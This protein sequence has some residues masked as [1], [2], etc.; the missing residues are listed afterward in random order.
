TAPTAAYKPVYPANTSFGWAAGF[1]QGW[2][3]ASEEYSHESEKTRY[4]VM[5]KLTSAARKKLSTKSFALPGRRYPI[6]DRAHAQ[7]AKARVS[8]FGTPSEKARVRAAVKRR[9]GFE[10]GGYVD[11]QLGKLGIKCY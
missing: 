2:A 10:K 3:G 5:A 4:Q 8:Q 6:P 9:Y 7:N 11:E 1:F